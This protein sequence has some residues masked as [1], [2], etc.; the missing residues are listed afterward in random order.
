MLPIDKQR[1]VLM[2]TQESQKDLITIIAKPA[3][4]SVSKLNRAE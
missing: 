1:I 4:F 3:Y 2:Y